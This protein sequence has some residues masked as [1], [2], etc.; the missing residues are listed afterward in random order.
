MDIKS[1]YKV[2]SKVKFN[3]DKNFSFSSGGTA[4]NEQ[5]VFIEPKVYDTLLPKPAKTIRIDYMNV[6]L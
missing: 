3:T 1:K 6:A 5:K 2:L 4:G